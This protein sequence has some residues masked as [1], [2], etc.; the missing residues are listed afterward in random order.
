[1]RRAFFVNRA[2]VTRSMA[3]ISPARERET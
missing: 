3:R 2:A 1:L